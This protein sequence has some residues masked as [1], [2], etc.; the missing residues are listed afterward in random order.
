MFKEGELGE[1]I[2]RTTIKSAKAHKN[3]GHKQGIRRR[4]SQGKE[5]ESLERPR[6]YYFSTKKRVLKRGKGL[7]DLSYLEKGRKKKKTPIK[8]AK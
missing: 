8:K 4:E 2:P 1:F 5:R 3:L 6:K 7:E